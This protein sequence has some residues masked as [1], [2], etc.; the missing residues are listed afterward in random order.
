M[1][2]FQGLDLMDATKRIGACKTAQDTRQTGNQPCTISVTGVVNMYKKV[3]SSHLKIVGSLG[4]LVGCAC[5]KGPGTSVWSLLIPSHTHTCPTN[6]HE[7]SPKGRLFWPPKKFDKLLLSS[8]IIP[9]FLQRSNAD[10]RKVRD[11]K[12]AQH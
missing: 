2:T 12:F 4:S 9:S 3:K 1:L 11:S 6:R 7:K 5:V 10:L 8:H